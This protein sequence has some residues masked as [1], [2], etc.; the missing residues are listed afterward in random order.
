[1]LYDLTVVQFSKMLKNLSVILEKGECFANLKKVDMAVLLNSRLAPDQFNLARQVQIACD[2]AKIG[3]A[4]LTDNL[5][6]VPKHDDNETTLAELQERISSVLAYLATFKAED[7]ANSA[8]IHVSQ[9]RWEG[10]YLTGYEFAVEHAIPNIYFHITTAYAILRHNG[11][12][13][14]KKDY[15]GAMPYKS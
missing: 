3:V 13:V 1:M 4:R 7:F 15:L 6:T 12:E 2:T 8:T 5:D 10:K 11:V 9:P 14:G